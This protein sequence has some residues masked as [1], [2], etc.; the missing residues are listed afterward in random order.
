MC[1][2]EWDKAPLKQLLST[3]I[4]NGYSPICDDEPNAL[5]ILSLGALNGNGLDPSQRK[6]APK[7]DPKVKQYF[8]SPG[9]FIVSRSNTLD[10][11]GRSA[12]F[13]GEIENCAYP[14]LMMRF[15]VRE[16]IVFLGYLAE[17]LR[18]EYA[19][20]YFKK[21]AAG[22][23]GSMKK[24]NKSVLEKLVVL[25]PPIEEQKQIA[26]I[27][28][29]WDEAIATTE[30]LIVAKQKLKNSLIQNLLAIHENKPCLL[31]GNW[32]TVALGDICKLN[33][34]KGLN[35]NQYDKFGESKVIGT[36]GI[37]G[38]SSYFLATGP[39]IVLGRKGSL[40]HP[41][42]VDKNEIFWAI[43]TTYYVCSSQNIKFLYYLFNFLRLSR[44]NESTG[45]P[46]L[47]RNTVYGIKTKIPDLDTQLKIVS[48]LDVAEMQIQKLQ[49]LAE[50]YKKQKRG[51]MQKLLTGEL[52]VAVKEA[53]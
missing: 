50:Y 28:A 53:A 46:S 48:V 2:K 43:D 36:A 33:Y 47:N 38:Y 7:N 17:Y 14:D 37:I 40:D 13:K 24:I 30:K 16:E 41:F 6:P 4:Q 26:E 25:L 22:T 3:S 8:L 42:Y 12:L 15:R 34:G 10:K 5:W 9:D 32:R 39:S 11:V 27:L 35:R 18:S 23:S 1:P 19:L 31:S 44:F 52:R 51:L 29:V 21:S 45:V 20:A 49:Q